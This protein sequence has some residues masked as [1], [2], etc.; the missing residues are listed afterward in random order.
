MYV[1]VWERRRE[2]ECLIVPQ[3]VSVWVCRTVQ[4]PVFVCVSVCVWVCAWSVVSKPNF[5][6][7]PFFFKH[8]QSKWF[9]RRL[10]LVLHLGHSEEIPQSPDCW[11]TIAIK[12]QASAKKK[13]KKERK[14]ENHPNSS[15]LTTFRMNRDQCVLLLSVSGWDREQTDD[16]QRTTD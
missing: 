15:T 12:R 9:R 7:W 10:A 2:K 11:D 1:W 6:L 4:T 8:H 13:G 16:S 3:I 14:K 5:I